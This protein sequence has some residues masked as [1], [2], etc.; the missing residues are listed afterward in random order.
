MWSC[1]SRSGKAVG[2]II[3]LNLWATV[4]CSN[5]VDVYN[6]QELSAAFYG[7][8][9]DRTLQKCFSYSALFLVFS[10]HLI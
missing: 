5:S 4:G 10:A 3:P 2:L 6:S 8:R 1:L 9:P 7:W